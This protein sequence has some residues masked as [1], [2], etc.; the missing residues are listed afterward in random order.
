MSDFADQ[1]VN[2]AL[3]TSEAYIPMPVDTSVNYQPTT[4][5]DGEVVESC[6]PG[7]EPG[8]VQGSF[9]AYASFVAPADKANHQVA[10]ITSPVNRG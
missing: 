3:K 7:A 6:S 2:G 1:D 9:H 8:T 10:G 4:H 5:E